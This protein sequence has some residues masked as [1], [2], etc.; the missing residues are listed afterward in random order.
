MLEWLKQFWKEYVVMEDL[1]L[2]DEAYMEYY[3][4]GPTRKE[5]Y[6]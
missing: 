2:L 5:N 1:E 3:G 4:N 6:E